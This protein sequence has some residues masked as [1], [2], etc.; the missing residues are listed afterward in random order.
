M[1][2]AYTN[3]STIKFWSGSA[4]DYTISSGGGVNGSDVRWKSEIQ[5]ITNALDKINNLQGKTF[6]Y[7]GNP[8]RQLGFIAQEVLPVVPEAVYIDTSDENNYH[9]LYYD[10]LV[11]LMNEGIKEQQIIINNNISAITSLNSRISVLENN[12]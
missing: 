4:I 12:I 1:I 7:N 11:A 10:K 3:N 6:I 5:N 2:T 9:F 8:N